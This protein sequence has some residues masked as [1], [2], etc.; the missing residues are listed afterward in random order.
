MSAKEGFLAAFSISKK[1]FKLAVDRNRMKRRLRE[2]FRAHRTAGIV[3]P[4]EYVFFF[5]KQAKNPSFQEIKD[6]MRA[7]FEKIR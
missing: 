4:G 5:T 2:S 1:Q 3:P 7:I 6:S